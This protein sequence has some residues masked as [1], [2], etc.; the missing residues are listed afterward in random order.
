MITPE[1]RYVITKAKANEANTAPL[2]KPNN[3]NT[4]SCVPIGSP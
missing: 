3:K 2:A 1:L 4:K